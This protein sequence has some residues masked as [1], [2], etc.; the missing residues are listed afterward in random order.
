MSPQSADAP[1]GGRDATPEQRPSD[2]SEHPDPGPPAAEPEGKSK[3]TDAAAGSHVDA[4]GMDVAALTDIGRTYRINCDRFAVL[5]REH[6]GGRADVFVMVA[7]GMGANRRGDTAS[8]LAAKVA[9]EALSRELDAA[10][11]S[12]TREQ[13][14]AALRR[15]LKA[16]NEAVWRAAQEDPELKG[17]GTTCVAAVVMGEEV[18]MCHA[19]DSRGY[20][21]SGGELTQ[22]TAD[23]SMIQEVVSTDDTSLGI[24]GRFGTVVTRGVGLSRLLESD[25]SVAR[26]KRDDALLLCTDGLTN[27]VSDRRIATIL[28]G[29]ASAEAACRSLVDE[30]NGA[31]GIDNIGVVVCRGAEF[32]PYVPG[33]GTGNADA[34]KESGA[35][36]SGRRRRRR[37]PTAPLAVAVVLA[38]VSLALAVLLFLATVERGR[39]QRDVE[40]LT[41]ELRAGQSVGR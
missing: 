27:M 14:L 18:L 2:A 33:A 35:K 13:V 9:P 4:G 21:L 31:G 22:L 12:A 28:A 34:L 16:A 41:E 40:R 17:M 32:V 36:Q 19:G 3:L 8:K 6:L 26:L 30:A 10:G 29:A 7:D 25:A 5:G 23:H 37:R 20:L 24:E 15:T 38:A 11:P 1:A 39:L